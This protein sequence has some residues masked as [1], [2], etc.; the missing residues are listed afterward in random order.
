MDITSSTRSLRPSVPPP[1][2]PSDSRR[3][4]LCLLLG[5]IGQLVHVLGV[6]DSLAGMGHLQE[7]EGREE[8][9]E[10]REEGRGVVEG[11]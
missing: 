7:E 1:S 5:G 3:Q 10:G 8:W 11:K 2:L 4:G 9:K 6:Q